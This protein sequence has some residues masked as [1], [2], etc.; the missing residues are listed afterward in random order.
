MRSGSGRH[1]AD[2]AALAEPFDPDPAAR[3]HWVGAAWAAVWRLL[4]GDP[5]R[6]WPTRELV[7]VMQLAQPGITDSVAKDKIRRCRAGGALR[8]LHLHAHGHGQLTAH[9]RAA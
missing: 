7:R 8:V 5:G 6:W 1:L 2:R 3:A 4:D 9:Y